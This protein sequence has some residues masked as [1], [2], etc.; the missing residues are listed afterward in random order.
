MLRKSSAWS[1]GFLIRGAP[2]KTVLLAMVA[3][4]SLAAFEMLFIA[5]FI[6]LTVCPIIAVCHNA[7]VKKY[8]NNTLD[9]KIKKV[10]NMSQEECVEQL[11]KAYTT[12][13]QEAIN[14]SSLHETCNS[15]MNKFLYTKPSKQE[16]GANLTELL[17]QKK[18]TQKTDEWQVL[19]KKTTDQQ[20][21]THQPQHTKV[22]PDNIKI[23]SSAYAKQNQIQKT[24]DN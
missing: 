1:Y 5:M 17:S 2:S 13:K 20:S 9:H 3:L 6:V 24:K 7:I 16:V 14:Q 4:A 8:I 11:K 12:L 18:Q 10:T 15:L 22:R 23:T 21:T 19:N